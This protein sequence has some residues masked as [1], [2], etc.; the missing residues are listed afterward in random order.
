[1]WAWY[2]LFVIIQMGDFLQK[3]NFVNIGGCSTANNNWAVA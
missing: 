1:M 2:L 3:G